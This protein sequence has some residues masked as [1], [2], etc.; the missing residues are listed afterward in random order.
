MT[1]DKEAVGR[2]AS[3][4]GL[5]ADN[6]PVSALS[7]NKLMF[8]GRCLFKGLHLLNG[9]AGSVTLSVYD[10]Q[11]ANGTLVATIVLATNTVWNPPIPDSGIICN[12]GVFLAVSAGPIN[13]SVFITPVTGARGDIGE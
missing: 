1:A 12:I 5:P 2:F 4:A 6:Q 13:G 3:V 9:N 10:G 11:D 7:A 8:G